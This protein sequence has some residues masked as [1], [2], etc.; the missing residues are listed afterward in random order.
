MKKEINI[1]QTRIVTKNK[2]RLAYV[3]RMCILIQG[4]WTRYRTLFWS[5]S[6]QCY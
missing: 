6:P 4:C 1:R 3:C 2:R 5:C